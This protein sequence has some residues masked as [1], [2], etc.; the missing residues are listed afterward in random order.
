MEL[1]GGGAMPKKEEGDVDADEDAKSPKMSV[2][3]RAAEATKRVAFERSAR[4]VRWAGV[5][6]IVRGLGNR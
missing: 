3:E 1:V 5:T 2:D 6:V 4:C